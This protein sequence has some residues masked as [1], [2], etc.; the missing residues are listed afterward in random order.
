MCWSWCPVLCVTQNTGHHDQ[1]LKQKYGLEPTY[2]YDAHSIYVLD[3]VKRLLVSLLNILSV[4]I[5]CVE[6]KDGMKQLI[7]SGKV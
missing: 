5:H 3:T 7:L 1:H 2:T 4:K 6:N